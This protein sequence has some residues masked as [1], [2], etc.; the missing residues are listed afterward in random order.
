MNLFSLL[1]GCLLRVNGLSAQKSKRLNS[2]PS[3]RNDEIKTAQ[4][5]KSFFN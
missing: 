4:V 5:L 3:M 1:G 2:L